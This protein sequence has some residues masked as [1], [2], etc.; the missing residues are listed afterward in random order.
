MIS[1]VSANLLYI[2]LVARSKGHLNFADRKFAYT[3]RNHA[4]KQK[5]FDSGQ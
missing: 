2:Q 3:T 1:S 4:R 5:Q